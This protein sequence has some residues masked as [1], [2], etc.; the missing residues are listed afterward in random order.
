MAPEVELGSEPFLD[1][2]EPELLQAG[3]LGLERWLVG[4]VVE[5]WATP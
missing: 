3:D 4:Q 5:R 2:R 1:C